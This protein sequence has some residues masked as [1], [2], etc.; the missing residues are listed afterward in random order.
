VKIL[1][2][3][4]FAGISGDMNL[5]A[6]IDLGVDPE[7]LREELRKIEIGSYEIQVKRDQRRGI[8]GTKVDVILP[9]GEGAPAAHGH[10]RSRILPGS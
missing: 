4:C 5:G 7:V 8:F 3:D 6:M 10:G 1:Y 9:S 2:Y